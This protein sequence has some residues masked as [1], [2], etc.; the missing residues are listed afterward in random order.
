MS[1]PKPDFYL[2]FGWFDLPEV[3]EVVIKKAPAEIQGLSVLFVSDVHLRRQVSDAQLHALIDLLK[4][5]KAD[6]LLLGGDYA[7]S[8]KDCARFFRALATV[9]PRL[10]CYGI[11]GNNDVECFPKAE[12]L[13]RL[14]VE[15]GAHLL[16]NE[17]VQKDYHLQIGGCDDHKNGSPDTKSLFSGSGY[18]ILLS[19]FPAKP[20]CEADLMLSGHTH[21]GQCN[22]LGLTPYAFGF[23]RQYGIKG[24][25]GM[26]RIG[27]IPLLV[28]KGIGASK[29]PVRMGVRPQVHLVKFTG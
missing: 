21:G 15:N 3:E 11:M 10:G 1:L 9:Q 19:H 22:F 25:S 18:R 27:N 16:V 14:M 24:V 28:S 6:L 12:E 7:E 8:A 4:A 26:N 23:E 20:D 29:L 17:W 5:Q 2:H 13:R